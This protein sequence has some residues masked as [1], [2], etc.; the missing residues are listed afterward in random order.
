M[1]TND[2]SGDR[3]RS[4]SGL[5]QHYPSGDHQMTTGSSICDP[6]DIN[7]AEFNCDLYLN[8]LLKDSTLSELMETEQSLYK[9]IQSL[10]SE[11]Q[12]LVYENYNKFISA[13]ET[14][15]KMSSHFDKMEEELT[16]LS[17]NMEEITKNS[18]QISTNLK[19]RRGDL[20][21]LAN[22]H[23]VLTKLQFLFE[24]SPKMRE[25][26]EQNQYNEAVKCYLRAEQTL[27]LYIHF[28]S[29]QAINEE[30]LIIVNQ[31]KDKLYQQLTNQEASPN[32]LN[33]SIELLLKLKEPT[34]KLC[35][36]YLFMVDKRLD[37]NFSELYYQNDLANKVVNTN[38]DDSQTLMDILE[39]IDIGCNGFLSNLSLSIQF[40]S[41]TFLQKSYNKLSKDNSIEII[42]TTLKE[43]V[44]KNMDKFFDIIL[45]RL[46]LEKMS[47]NDT[48]V[49]VRAVDR[50]YKRLLTLNRI[51]DLSDFSIKAMSIVEKASEDQCQ[52]LLNYLRIKYQEELTNIR[53]SILSTTS[54]QTVSTSRHIVKEKQTITDLLITLQTSISELVKSVVAALMPFT[55]PEVTFAAKTQFQQI[56][57]SRFARE[58]VVIGFIRHILSNSLEYEKNYS[59]ATSPP[60]QLILLLSRLCLDF[61]TSIIGYLL[62]FTDEQFNIYNNN[63]NNQNITSV[64]DLCKE[65]RETAQKLLNHYVRLEGHNISQMIRKSV[66]TRDWL[67]TVEPRSVRSVMKR[68]IEDISQIDS[69]VGQ[70]YEEGLRLERSSDSSKSRRTFSA[71]GVG[72]RHSANKSSNWSA[73]GPSTF[74]NSLMSNIQKLFTERIEIFGSVEFSRLSVLTGVIKI[75]LKTLIE[76][77]RLCTFSRYGLQ[78]MQVDSYYLQ[79]HVW[80]YASDENLVYVLIDEVLLSAVHRCIDA[81]MMEMSVVEKICDGF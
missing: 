68:V 6:F 42:K 65:A 40:F 56:F 1:S 12:T 13:T 77:V 75:G 31:L 61:E 5:K 25:S 26:I 64:S 72:N 66:E 70:L 36:E 8:K 18:E 59:T 46:H 32:Q 3:P 22:T 15:Q 50:L 80:Q 76:C 28:P 30:C 20:S 71:I 43:F 29:I 19:G 52:Q 16:L 79:T 14:I 23:D 38:S 9:Q 21:K 35:R 44:D 39:Y 34:E 17:T 48:V 27:G 60:S 7:S 37:I 58:V 41:D 47:L 45:K 67:S 81:V 11:M 55:D 54:L 73:Y 63:G 62:S 49:F 51:Y 4:R 57:S 10:D 24:L 2:I 78:Q 53:H 74:D 69:Q 33:E